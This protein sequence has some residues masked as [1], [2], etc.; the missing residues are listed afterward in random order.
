MNRYLR[1][2]YRLPAELEESVGVALADQG[3]LGTEVRVIT[4]GLGAGE[5]EL[6]AWYPERPEA[7]PDLPD[8]PGEA[9]GGVMLTSEAWI[10]DRDWLAEY[11]IHAKPRPVGSRFLVDP[12]EPHDEPLRPEEIGE[13]ILL[14]LPARE[15]FGTGSHAST[16]LV[17]SWIE[18]LPIAG[19]RVLDVGCGSGILAFGAAALGAGFVA[20]F[21]LDR[22]SVSLAG[23]N[24]RRNR[25]RIRRPGTSGPWLFAGGIDSLSPSARFDLVLVNVLPDRVE[26]DVPEIAARVTPGGLAVV[27]GFLAEE[28][29]A[30][31]AVWAERGLRRREERRDEEWAGA[32]LEAP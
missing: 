21:D 32:L 2:T 16:R 28:A 15:A 17:L 30:V 4:D 29:D 14:Q 18:D 13:R 25:T 12:R 5:V 26:R 1:R 7:R 6:V 10:A 19:S 8:L 9:S 11:R 23:E 22:V 3:S 31:L 24:L 20:G 27:S